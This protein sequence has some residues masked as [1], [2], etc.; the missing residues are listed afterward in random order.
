MPT[1][2]LGQTEANAEEKNDD[3]DEGEEEEEAPVIFKSCKSKRTTIILDCK[4]KAIA[5]SL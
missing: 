1:V 4:G 3:D 2:Q 5:E